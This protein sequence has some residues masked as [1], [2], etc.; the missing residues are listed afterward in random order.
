M[1]LSEHEQRI[2]D[3]IERRLAED[4]P[5]FARGVS[6][7]GSHGQS[8]R[9]LKRAFVGFILG[10]VL[11]LAGLFTN[12]LV[13]LG[14]VAFIVMLASSVVIAAAAK[15]IGK[16]RATAMRSA[17]VERPFGKM[18]ERWRKRFDKDE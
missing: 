5:K 18:E 6:T 4:D 9:K 2:L 14:I 17:K 3:E 10:F 15:H 7:A 8:V 16:E 11:L 1:P 12:Q 13:A